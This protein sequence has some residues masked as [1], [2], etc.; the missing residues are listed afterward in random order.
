MKYQFMI[1]KTKIPHFALSDDEKTRISYM[2]HTFKP[3]IKDKKF[4]NPEQFNLLPA[5][6]RYTIPHSSTLPKLP[7]PTHD[8]ILAI[9]SDFKHKKCSLKTLATLFNEVDQTYTFVHKQIEFEK[10][11]PYS[12]EMKQT[13]KNLVA[14]EKFTPV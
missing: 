12:V 3:N 8:H 9:H 11:L 14:P 1:Q 10:V 13:F 2:I 6:E 5:S 4:R 7:T